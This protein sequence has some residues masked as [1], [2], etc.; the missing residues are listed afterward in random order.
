MAR[1][2]RP[3]GTEDHVTPANGKTFTLEEMQRYVG[4]YIELMPGVAPMRMIVDEE[5]QLKNKPVNVKATALVFERLKGQK[6]RYLPTIV[7]DVLVLE[8]GERM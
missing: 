7:G 4:G 8:P 6:L 1:L 3:D 5:G 2:I